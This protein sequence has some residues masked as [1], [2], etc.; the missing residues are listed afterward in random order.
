MLI[1]IALLQLL[2][3]IWVGFLHL[4]TLALFIFYFTSFIPKNSLKKMPKEK[5]KHRHR[6]RSRERRDHRS[7]DPRSSR[8][9]DRDRER[10]REKDRD[11][12][13]TC[14]KLR[15]ITAQMGSVPVLGSSLARSKAWVWPRTQCVCSRTAT[16]IV[17]SG[18]AATGVDGFILAAAFSLALL[19][20]G[21]LAYKLTHDLTP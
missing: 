16:T 9:R 3:A 19:L 6:S 20:L 18:M 15:S 5:S 13:G 8:N 2:V 14:G 1:S 4:A 17:I 11:H 7:P 21:P 10:E 12:R